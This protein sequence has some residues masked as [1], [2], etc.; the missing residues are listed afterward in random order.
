MGTHEA[1]FKLR[2]CMLSCISCINTFVCHGRG[3]K[4]TVDLEDKKIKKEEQEKNKI[5][6][7]CIT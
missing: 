5:T 1:S 4:N 7:N 2:A 3:S 6:R